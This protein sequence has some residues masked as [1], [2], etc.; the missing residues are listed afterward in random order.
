MTNLAGI[1]TAGIRYMEGGRIFKERAVVLQYCCRSPLGGPGVLIEFFVDTAFFIQSC[2]HSKL[3]SLLRLGSDGICVGLWIATR[4]AAAAGSAGRHLACLL[5]LLLPQLQQGGWMY[6]S[7][8]NNRGD[9]SLCS[10]L[11]K[12]ALETT[13]AGCNRMTLL[14]ARHQ[15]T[16][17]NK[18]RAADTY[19]PAG[20]SNRHPT[21][22]SPDN[23]A[24]AAHVKMSLQCRGG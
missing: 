5:T 1:R 3:E 13:Q 15:L 16:C 22:N 11:C 21:T 4:T 19:A 9:V 17:S 24:L 7:L 8:C 20:K 2:C 10:L 14:L 12:R 23:C 18:A 6:N